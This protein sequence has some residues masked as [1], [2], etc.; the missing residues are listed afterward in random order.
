MKTLLKM[1]LADN[2]VHADLHPGNILVRMDASN[3]ALGRLLRLQPKPHIV[4]LDCGMTASL[5]DRNKTN[6]LNFFTVRVKR[7]GRE[8]AHPC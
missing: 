6:L 1:M 8:R 4:L 3:S 2:L 5:S 7:C